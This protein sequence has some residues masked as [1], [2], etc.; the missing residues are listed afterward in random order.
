MK[1]YLENLKRVTILMAVIFGPFIPIMFLMSLSP[2]FAILFP[3]A[4]AMMLSLI[5]DCEKMG[6]L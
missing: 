4:F 1:N 5:D 3:F 2:W 6:W